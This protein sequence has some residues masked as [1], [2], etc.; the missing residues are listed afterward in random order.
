MSDSRHEPR[1]ILT[2]K[3]N[4]TPEE[5]TAWERLFAAEDELVDACREVMRATSRRGAVERALVEP[6]ARLL[7]RRW[8]R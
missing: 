4:M 3:N 2:S 8:G 1:H 7:R 6:A 5:Q